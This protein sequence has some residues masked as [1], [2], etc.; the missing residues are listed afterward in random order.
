MP[1][2]SRAECAI[3]VA[4]CGASRADGSCPAASQSRSINCRNGPASWL[5]IARFARAS[6]RSGRKE[7]T[8]TTTALNSVG[9]IEQAKLGEVTARPCRQFLE[10]LELAFVMRIA[11]A[12]W[13]SAGFAGALSSTKARGG[14]PCLTSAMSGRP[15]PGFRYSG[16]TVNPCRTGRSWISPSS[17]CWKAGASAGSGTSGFA[18]RSS[19]MRCA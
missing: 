12:S 5:A 18:R 17:N 9:T 19:R 10:P 8:G 16:S 7:R 14:A 13:E 1:R 2:T 3:S 15:T 6:S 4:R 11:P